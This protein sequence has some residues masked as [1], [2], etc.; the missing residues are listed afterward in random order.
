ML[1]KAKE[2][3]IQE[4]ARQKKENPANLETKLAK[5]IDNGNKL[6][7]KLRAVDNPAPYSNSI[8]QAA[9]Y[10]KMRILEAHIANFS[11]D[12]GIRALKM[13]ETDPRTGRN[14]LH[15]LA[16]MANTDMIQLLGVTD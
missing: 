5:R 14:A 3:Q 13:N 9:R 10:N 12:A 8:L 16:Y 4:K 11:D 6:I 1:N 2:E 15:Y 7:E